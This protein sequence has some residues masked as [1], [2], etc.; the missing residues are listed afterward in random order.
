[1]ARLLR[2]NRAGSWYHITARANERKAIYRDERDR[3]HFVELFAP[4]RK[5]F[6]L[7][8]HAC[9]LMD[10]HYHLLLETTEANLSRAM[11]A[12]RIDQPQLAMFNGYIRPMYDTFM[13]H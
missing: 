5:R 10:N 7:R 13:Q 2:L 3:S 8:L 6:R 4:W 1:M 9:V 12:C 11:S